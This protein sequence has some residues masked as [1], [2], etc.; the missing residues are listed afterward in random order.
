M[1]FD[2]L[3][4]GISRVRETHAFTLIEALI[5]VVMVAFTA[6]IVAALYFAGMQTLEAQADRAVLDS[7]MRSRMEALVST[8]FDQLANGNE[9]VT[10]GSGTYTI[11]W[12]VDTTGPIGAPTTDFD[13]DLVPEATAK[14]LVVSVGTTSLTMIVVDHQGK[15][16]PI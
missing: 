5:S 6:T 3:Q 4:S 13:G 10:V 9:V 16:A 14:L 8:K 2:R 11:S 1:R 7:M 15:V 12:T